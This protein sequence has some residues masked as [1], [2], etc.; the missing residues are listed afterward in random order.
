M[1]DDLRPLVRLIRGDLPNEE[2]NTDDN[3]RYLDEKRREVQERKRDHSP[4]AN[5]VEFSDLL[6]AL[7][8]ATGNEA[9]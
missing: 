8:E 1:T 5:D 7:A 2:R 6:R 4:N 9:A 3:I